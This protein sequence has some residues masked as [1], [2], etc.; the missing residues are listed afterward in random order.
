VTTVRATAPGEAVIELPWLCPGADALA[1]L[2]RTPVPWTTVRADPG[3]V[4][5]AVRNSSAFANPSHALSPGHLL[6][7]LLIQSALRGL[8]EHAD[9]GFVDWSRDGAREVLAAALDCARLARRVA[10]ATSRSPPE[11]A[12]VGGLLAPLGWLAVCAADPDYA[13]DCLADPGHARHPAAVERRHWG[14]D[15]AALARRLARRWELPAW[16]S[17]IVGYLGLPPEDARRCG[18]SPDLFST[19]RLGVALAQRRGGAL[20]LC[21]PGARDEC[22]LV[23]GLTPAALDEL[24]AT[25]EDGKVE[26]GPGVPARRPTDVP[27][28]TDLLVL[29]EENRRLRDIPTQRR[30]EGEADAL[31]D[32]LRD[33]RAGEAE[34]LRAQKLA[35]L[36]ELAAGAGHEINNPL[37]VI[38]GQAQFLLTKLRAVKPRALAPAHEAGRAGE[39]ETGRG[40]EGEKQNAAVS[41]SP[42]LPLSLSQDEAEPALRKIVE[43]TQRIHQILRELMQFARPPQPHRQPFDAGD[44]VQEVAASLAELAAQRHVRMVVSRPERP[45]SLCADPGQVRTALTCLLRNA[46]EA[47][48]VEGWAALRLETHS[49]DAVEIVVEDNGPGPPP[50]QREHLFDPFYCGRSAGRGRGLGLPTAWRLARQHGG[51]VHFVS[52]PDGPTR[53]VLTLPVEPPSSPATNG[54]GAS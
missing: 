26:P 27:L 13:R 47:A 10:E 16:L 12:W 35:S 45:V 33:A 42:L 34:R 46:V 36:A 4:L 30:G 14:F 44:L 17:A 50:Q 15:Q 54:H 49:P 8:R 7:P 25:A 1:A 5:L 28:L 39:G 29:A 6:E 40:G 48:P 3:A 9:S 22:A 38:S 11:H 52:L 41:P 21:P 18:G 23:L 43:Q 53:F 51:D 32:A 2:A 24:E 20:R 31:A 37:A 19:V